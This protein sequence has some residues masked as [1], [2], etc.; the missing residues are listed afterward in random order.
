[1]RIHGCPMLGIRSVVAVSIEDEK[2]RKRERAYP[3]DSFETTKSLETTGIRSQI[4][5]EAIG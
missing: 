3:D 2:G 5:F 4:A 1:M